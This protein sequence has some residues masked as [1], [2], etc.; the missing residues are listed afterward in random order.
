HAKPAIYLDTGEISFDTIEIRDAS[1][2][3][4][5]SVETGKAMTIVLRYTLRRPIK[6]L[7]FHIGFVTPDL[8]RVTV[9]NSLDEPFPLINEKQGTV[10]CHIRKLPLMPGTY[11]LLVSVKRTN[12]ISLFKGE[13][14]VNFK[15]VD[16]TFTYIR[17]NMELVAFDVEWRFS[18]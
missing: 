17:R 5:D 9:F 6:D 15:V 1:G 18:K 16:P 10:E 4:S 13:N 12:N 14:L 11:G 8:L 3:P 7:V 2:K